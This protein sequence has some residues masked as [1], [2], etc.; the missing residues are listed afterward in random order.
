MNS[1]FEGAM[2]RPFLDPP[3][4]RVLVL[5]HIRDLLHVASHLEEEGSARE[6]VLFVDKNVSHQVRGRDL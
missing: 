2:H 1:H 4:R 6:L 5:D 3:L